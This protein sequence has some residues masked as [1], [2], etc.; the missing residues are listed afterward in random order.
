MTGIGQAREGADGE[1]ALDALMGYR[2][3]MLIITPDA[4]P[5][6]EDLDALFDEGCTLVLDEPPS[7]F[8]LSASHVDDPH[9]TELT[10]TLR[11]Q[12]PYGGRTA[13]IE[14]V[15]IQLDGQ[16]EPARSRLG[17]AVQ[18]EF[19]PELRAGLLR[20]LQEREAGW[21]DLSEVPTPR[22]WKPTDDLLPFSSLMMGGGLDGNTLR[23][24]L[25]IIR[26]GSVEWVIHDHYCANPQ[27]DCNE[28]QFAFLQVDPEPDELT[29]VEF[30]ARV[31]LGTGDIYLQD[32]EDIDEHEALFLVQAFLSQGRPLE[33]F[34]RRLI[35]SKRFGERV[36]R[37]RR[38]PL[39]P[40]RRISRNG[41]CP[42]G[43]GKKYKSCCGR[44]G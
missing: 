25:A 20:L 35:E 36:L 43:S 29:G 31:D 39:K 17:R 24:A 12:P 21:A 2:A 22:R 42:C 40:T 37:A 26:Q 10:L 4:R 18:E 11:E 15:Q 27:C 30:D 1:E 38:A 13:L 28:V 16:D 32:R 19:S 5:L 3:C 44:K 7:S 14:R 33:Q 23:G 8:A 41:P 34:R 6:R 9:N